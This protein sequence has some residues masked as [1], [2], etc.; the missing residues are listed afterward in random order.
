MTR[1]LRGCLLVAA[2]TASVTVSALEMPAQGLSRD[3]VIARFGTPDYELPPVGK[4]A[5]TRWVYDGFTVYFE[6]RTVIHAVRTQS[7]HAQS[8]PVAPTQPAVAPVRRAEPSTPAV[9]P[10]VAP[11]ADSGFSPATVVEEAAPV[12]VAPTPVAEAQAPIYTPPAAPVVEAPAAAPAAPA[13]AGGGGFYFDPATGR[14]VLEGE[15]PPPAVTMP[16]EPVAPP[17]ASAFA[18]E[19]VATPAPPAKP[20][21][22]AEPMP[23]ATPEPDAETPPAEIEAVF[24]KAAPV[25]L[26]QPAAAVE[27]PKPAPR[28]APKPAPAAD[29]GFTGNALDAEL[30]FDP[31][32]G[33]FRPAK[34]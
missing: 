23:S 18:P 19:P 24:E 29:D 11:A 1:T 5:I 31:E 9:A 12:P 8:A 17:D 3:E 7:K 34:R 14:L 26:T 20:M 13:A 25:P 22:A 28:P 10:V 4:P 15:A 6:N 27:A 16:N 21:P 33:T 2:M 30:E 32:T